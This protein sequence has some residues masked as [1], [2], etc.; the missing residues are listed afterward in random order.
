MAH[1]SVRTSSTAI[2]STRRSSVS[3]QILSVDG[4]VA[5]SASPP[6]V[7]DA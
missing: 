6:S 7:L 2:S 3:I 1:C 5:R 4:A